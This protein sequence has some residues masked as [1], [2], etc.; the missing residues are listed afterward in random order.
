MIYEYHCSG[1]GGSFDVVKPVSEFDKEELC[2][3]SQVTMVRAF[4][5]HKLHLYNTAVGEKEYNYALGTVCTPGQAKRIAKE[6][7][8]IEVG[9][10]NLFKHQKV[11][12]KE[13]DI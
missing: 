6:R 11:K 9:N 3:T 4:A 13:F 12:R 7:G 8:L 5:P 1:C 2:P 10:E